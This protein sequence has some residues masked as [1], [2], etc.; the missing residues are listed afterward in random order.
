MSTF[1]QLNSKLTTNQLKIIKLINKNKSVDLNYLLKKIKISKT[2]L[3]HEL[4]ELWSNSFINTSSNTIINSYYTLDVRGER[5]V[6]IQ[7]LESKERLKEKF[8]GFIFGVLSSIAVF[9][10]TKYLIPLWLK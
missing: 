6:S 2:A 10:L 5:N 1:N 3:E 8:I 9:I 7:I 4:F